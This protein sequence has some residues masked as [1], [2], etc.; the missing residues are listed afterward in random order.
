MWS[1][2]LLGRGRSEKSVSAALDACAGR[3]RQ[4]RVQRNRTG[5]VAAIIP[6]HRSP[7]W[8]AM[9]I[10]IIL[11]LSLPRWLACRRFDI[12]NSI[13]RR[14]GE[15]L[16]SSQDNG[17]NNVACF[18]LHEYANIWWQ[19]SGQGICWVLKREKRGQLPSFFAC[20]PNVRFLQRTK[21]RG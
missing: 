4:G 7:H 5:T 14:Y 1:S 9:I 6:Q 16:C 21:I 19:A 20:A 13:W 10:R 8:W 15:I 2:V 12:K 18:H 11:T 3:S 17:Y